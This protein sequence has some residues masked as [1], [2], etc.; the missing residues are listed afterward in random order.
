[1]K[2]ICPE[3]GNEIPDDSKFCYNC[4]RS[5]KD[6][7]KIDEKGNVLQGNNICKTCGCEISPKDLFCQH[8]GTAITKDQMVTTFKPKMAKNGWIGIALAL[9]PGFVNI[10]GLGHLWFKRYKRAALYL[11]VS[12]PLFYLT[13]FAELTS[14]Y[15]TILFITSLFIY[16]IQAMEAFTLAFM[17]VQQ[18]KTKKE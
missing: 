5:N 11:I 8:C 15:S 9:G 1:M 16:F 10:F 18:K 17:P 13:Y 6:A 2:T 7:I 4:G 3:C 14:Y 12:I